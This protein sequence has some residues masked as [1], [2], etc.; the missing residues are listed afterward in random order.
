[1][2]NALCYCARCSLPCMAVWPGPVHHP[3]LGIKWEQDMFVDTAL[4]FVP[5]KLFSAFVDVEEE[6]QVAIAL[7]YS[8]WTVLAVNGPCSEHAN[9]WESQLPY[10]KQSL[11]TCLTFLD[12]PFPDV[13]MERLPNSDETAT[14]SP[15]PPPPAMAIHPPTLW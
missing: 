10:T 12:I 11:A 13:I 15:P 7:H 14:N 5:P 4:P 9:C 6:S 2:P 1:M 8:S 3:F